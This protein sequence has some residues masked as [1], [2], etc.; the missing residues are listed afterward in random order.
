[1]SKNRVIIGSIPGLLPGL[2]PGLRF[3]YPGKIFF[4]PFQ[5]GTGRDAKLDNPF[6]TRF[7]KIKLKNL[8]ES[9][10]SAPI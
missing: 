3:F 2:L 1:M 9:Q 8:P 10:N 6:P 7:K 5:P 4:A